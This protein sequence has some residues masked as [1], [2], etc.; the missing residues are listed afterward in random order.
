MNRKILALLIASLLCFGS[1]STVFASSEAD[2][3]ELTTTSELQQYINENNIVVPEG[4]TLKSVEFDFI[5][6]PEERFENSNPIDLI[7]PCAIGDWVTNVEKVKDDVYFPD[8]EITSDFYDGPTEST[9]YTFTESV[10]AKLTSSLGCSISEI[11]AEVGFEV[12]GSVEKS[13]TVTLKGVN[14]DE[15][16]GVKVYGV[17]DKYSFDVYSIFNNYQG[18]E[19]AYKPMGLY[20]AQETYEKTN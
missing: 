12:T 1:F 14:A 16:L 5:A 8:D 6:N 18:T 17:Y 19:Y 20:V 13:K 15:I 2:S 9:S 7:Q 11:S 3:F 4:Y 10:E